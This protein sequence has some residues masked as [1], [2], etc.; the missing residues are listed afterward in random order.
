LVNVVRGFY[1]ELDLGNVKRGVELL[2]EAEKW[3]EL[4]DPGSSHGDGEDLFL[5]AALLHAMNPTEPRYQKLY[6]KKIIAFRAWLLSQLDPE[7]QVLHSI[8]RIKITGALRLME[9]EVFSG[10]ASDVRWQGIKE[11]ANRIVR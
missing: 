2:Q 1:L 7:D 11:L 4:Q 9:L 10:L 3:V 5:A 8:V 6:D